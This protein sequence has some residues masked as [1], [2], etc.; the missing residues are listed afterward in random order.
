ML[1][2]RRVI[3]HRAK[4]PNKP[5]SASVTMQN[6][7]E[8]QRYR[9]RRGDSLRSCASLVASARRG[10]ACVGRQRTRERWLQV[11]RGVGFFGS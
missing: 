7:P 2:S 1:G 3:A 11:C 10:G 5:D 4:L 9:T 6:R 8:I